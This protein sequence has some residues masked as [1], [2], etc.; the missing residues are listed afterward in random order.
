MAQQAINQAYKEILNECLSLDEMARSVY[1][2]L[3][4]SPGMPELEN[5]WKDMA[6]EETL[7]I[8]Y[9]NKLIEEAGRGMIPHVLNDPPKVLADLGSVRSNA[10]VLLARFRRDMSAPAAFFLA[11]RLEIMMMHPALEML[12]TFIQTVEEKSSPMDEYERHLEKLVKAMSGY[13]EDNPELGLINETVVKMWSENK[14]L[15]VQSHMDELTGVL[16]R[17]G[18][19]NTIKLLSYLAQRNSA[20]VGIMMLDIDDFKKVN[21]TKGHQE[22]DRVLKALAQAVKSC[23]RTSD[24]LGRYGGEEF[25]IFL[26]PVRP[27]HLAGIGDKIRRAVEETAAVETRV[28]ISIG[29]SC[30]TIRDNVN[31]ELDAL[32][33]SADQALYSAKNN[34]KNNVVVSNT[35]SE[36]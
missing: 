7:H 5:L 34:G 24:V 25:L 3:A 18:L 22:G 33:K 36:R 32:I 29:I 13:I 1:L 11:C 19:F 16:N 20:P 35:K 6:E 31:S 9:W 21:D 12:F 15:L 14:R 28:T 17:R 26:S 27:E 10:Q 2:E 4:A 23:L 8:S 30:G